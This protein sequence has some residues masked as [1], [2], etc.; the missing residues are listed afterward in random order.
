MT[1]ALSSGGE[2]EHFDAISAGL[3]FQLP[4]AMANFGF[5]PEVIAKIGPVMSKAMTSLEGAMSGLTALPEVMAG[6][7]GID[8]SVMAAAETAGMIEMI[9]GMIGE[10]EVQ[11]LGLQDLQCRIWDTVSAF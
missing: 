11:G 6:G 4:A 2:L 10:V 7:G 3:N 5:N 1:A 9:N 8:E